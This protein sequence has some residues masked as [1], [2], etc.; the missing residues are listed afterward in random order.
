MFEFVRGVCVVVFFVKHERMY[1]IGG[2]AGEIRPKRWHL[3]IASVCWFVVQSMP[4]HKLGSW[5]TSQHGVFLRIICRAF[6]TDLFAAWV[7]TISIWHF[8]LPAPG[9]DLQALCNWWMVNNT[10]HNKDVLLRDLISW[11]SRH[12]WSSLTMFALRVCTM[13]QWSEV[14]WTLLLV[15][16]QPLCTSLSLGLRRLWC[17]Q[18]CLSISYQGRPIRHW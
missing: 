6:F 7:R 5:Q 17:S 3:H 2:I 11:W 9:G 15:Q 13:D 10:V 18:I 14:V 16:D 8:I 1:L 4:F 12:G